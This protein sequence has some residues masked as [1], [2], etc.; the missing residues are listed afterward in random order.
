VSGAILWNEVEKI[1][2]SSK[3]SREI[4]IQTSQAESFS[5]LKSSHNLKLLSQKI[6]I[7]GLLLGLPLDEFNL[8]VDQ[9]DSK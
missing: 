9:E 7:F 6:P 2:R 1:H 5:L 8:G 3:S 4:C